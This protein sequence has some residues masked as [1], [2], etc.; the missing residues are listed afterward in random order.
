MK[1]QKIILPDT[2]RVSWMVID[3]N[4]LPLEPI[5]KYLYYLESTGKSPNTIRSY[6]YHLKLYWE[7]LKDRSLQW[8]KINIENLAFFLGWLQ[9]NDHGKIIS[10][11]NRGIKRSEKTLNTILT[12]VTMMYD[13]HWRIG[14]VKFLNLYHQKPGTRTDYKS[15]LHHINKSQAIKAKL[16][17]VKNTKRIPKIL[18]PKEVRII[19]DSCSRLRDK[20]LV[21]LLYET[22]MRIGQ[23]LGLRHEDIH[24]W[25][26]EIIIN[27]WRENENGARSKSDDEIKI[28]VSN[29]LMQLYTDYLL[30]EYGDIDSDYVFVNL[31]KGKIGS[32]LNYAAVIS[33]FRSLT[34]KT[35]I[36]ITPHIFRHTHATELL[37]DGW[38]MSHV[39]RRL[40]HKN[41]QT[42]INT[43]SH[44]TDDEYVKN[45]FKKYLEKKNG[46]WS[47]NTI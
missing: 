16:L 15:F 11:E 18:T 40:G 1:V 37:K 6:A 26:N 34:R 42:T 43:Y 41:I 4:H 3:D 9:R 22:G 47:Q 21:L 25:D 20:F 31:W 7:Y 45:E 13:Y 2:L 32:P 35:G 46:E 44:V 39:Q 27:P 33:K 29:E 14:S 17:K 24:S 30:T 5:Q 12:A 28:H 10:I 36:K 23:A 38:D 19:V 8:D